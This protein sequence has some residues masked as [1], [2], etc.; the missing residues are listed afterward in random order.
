MNAKKQDGNGTTVK[1][2]PATTAIATKEKEAVAEV[3]ATL[4][5]QTGFTNQGGFALL[6]RSAILLS[7]SELVPTIFQGNVPNCAVAL[8]MAL[9][10][11]ASPL[12]VMQN[13]YIVHGKPS[14]SSS[15]IIAA[16]NTTGKFSPLRYRLTG[17]EGTDERTCIAW[18][19]EKATGEVLESPPISI[20]IAKKEGWYA[21]NG[22]KWQTMP[23]LM[24][25]YRAATLFGRLYAPEVLM[26]MHTEEEVIDITPEPD[27]MAEKK[28]AFAEK[29]AANRAR[30]TTPPVEEVAPE[31]ELE[32]V[33]VRQLREREVEEARATAG[34][35]NGDVASAIIGI[36]GKHVLLDELTDEQS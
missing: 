14:W 36:A 15:F 8:E 27:P 2:E 12:M 18:A 33:N 28:I 30:M 25:R 19:T 34:W 5:V 1:P 31:P 22:S 26:G 29:L 32:P 4:P 24:L 20:G 10:M 7:Q 16:T 23:E 3:I 35:A 13:L 21:R 11:G 6:Q 17:K 9:R